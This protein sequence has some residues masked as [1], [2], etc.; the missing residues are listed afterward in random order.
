MTGEQIVMAAI[1]RRIDSGL[2]LRFTN[3]GDRPEPFVCYPK[4]D[5]QKAEWL[6]NAAARGWELLA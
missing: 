2:V 3:T 1:A 5:A 6:R 4:D